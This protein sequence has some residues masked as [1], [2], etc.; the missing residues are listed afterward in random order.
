MELT[1]K[2][3]EAIDSKN[4]R[5]KI[6]HLAEKNSWTQGFWKQQFNISLANSTKE[7]KQFLKKITQVGTV[8][9]LPNWN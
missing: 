9:N 5:K 1:G 4:N 8:G 3:F 2:P 7:T 6:P